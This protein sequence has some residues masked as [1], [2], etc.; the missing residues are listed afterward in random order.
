MDALLSTLR[1]NSFRGRI[2]FA[3]MGSATIFAILFLIVGFAWGHAVMAVLLAI[4]TLVVGFVF[5]RMLENML[6]GPVEQLTRIAST[7]SKGDF[8]LRADVT[9]DDA[10]GE[11]ARAF[12]S[13]VDKLSG[14]LKETNRITQLVADSGRNIYVKNENMKNVIDQATT[15]AAELAQGSNQVSEEVIR[16][17]QSIKEIE[18]RTNSY[19]E[20]SKAMNRHAGQ[21]LSLVEEGKL[22]VDHQSEGI[23]QNVQTTQAVSDTIRRLAQQ[24]SGIT[25]ITRTISEIAEQTNLLSLNASIEAARAGEHGKGF[26]VV[27]QQVRKLAEESTAST[28][29]VFALVRGIDQGIREALE[30]IKTNEAVVENQV[31]LIDETEAVFNRFVDSV[32]FVSKQ[33]DQ[34]ANESLQMLSSARQISETMENISAITEEAAA[35]TEE[36]S[37]SLSRQISAVDDM[38]QQAYEMTNNVSQLQRTISIFRL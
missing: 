21:M 23:K 11:L 24:A 37:T 31:K 17:A 36:V 35:G 3:L 2:Y 16:T 29:E 7:I 26:A 9:S 28:R 22:K 13:M 10:L 32:D 6:I 30:T 27:A 4:I 33:I 8:T 34:F 5:S 19:T 25:A 14:I 1:L 15:S 38:L 20:S 12:N 18:E